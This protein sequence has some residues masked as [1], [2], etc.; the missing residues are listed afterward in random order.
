MYY[1]SCSFLNQKL[2]II[3]DSTTERT[4]NILVILQH[5]AECVYIVKS[6]KQCSIRIL[7]FSPL[8]FYV[9]PASDDG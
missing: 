2:K 8:G 3:Y 5:T 1:F 9:I 4:W 6:V 7:E